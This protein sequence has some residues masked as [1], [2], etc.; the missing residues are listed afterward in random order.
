[1]RSV[2]E[3]PSVNLIKKIYRIFFTPQNRAKIKSVST[4]IQQ[5][6]GGYILADDFSVM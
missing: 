5:Q 6:K 1:M 3:S 4:K 2:D